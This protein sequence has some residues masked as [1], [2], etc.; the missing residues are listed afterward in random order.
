MELSQKIFT[1]QY[2]YIKTYNPHK[3]ED[4]YTVYRNSLA[5][6]NGFCLLGRMEAM[7][8]IIGSP[9]A[10]M[11]EKLNPK[12][13]VLDANSSDPSF[14][15]TNTGG[16]GNVL[17]DIDWSLEI[18]DAWVLGGIHGNST[19]NFVGEVKKLKDFI[20]DNI[21]STNPTYPVTVTAREILA[22]QC[23][24]YTPKVA[25]ECLVFVPPK[26]GVDASFDLKCYFTNIDNFKG[27]D[28]VKNI[29][30]YINVLG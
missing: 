25:H 7:N 9:P 11:K 28:L 24:G 17:R 14:F 8:K 22:L 6:H 13:L 21:T 18:N 19:F 27:N 26:N 5:N 1:E 3:R 29:G 4:A 16:S 30:K 2:N 15:A 10:D 12:F 23:A 20:S